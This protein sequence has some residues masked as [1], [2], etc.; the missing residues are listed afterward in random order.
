MKYATIMSIVS[1]LH[2]SKSLTFHVEL[3]QEKYLIRQVAT[4]VMKKLKWQNF[5]VF[6]ATKHIIKF[7]PSCDIW[8]LGRKT[9]KLSSAVICCLEAQ[10]T[11]YHVVMEVV[12]SSP[13]FLWSWCRVIVWSNLFEEKK[14]GKSVKWLIKISSTKNFVKEFFW[15]DLWLLSMSVRAFWVI[16]RVWVAFIQRKW[17]SKRLGEQDKWWLFKNECLIIWHVDK[18]LGVLIVLTLKIVLRF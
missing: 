8:K 14:E 12:T 10:T 16:W 2:C 15:L 11:K 7:F 13:H 17:R 5:F 3:Y 9:A 18:I 1:R 6:Y 4:S